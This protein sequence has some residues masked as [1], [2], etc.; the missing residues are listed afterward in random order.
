[1]CIG[2]KLFNCSSRRL[3]RC[4]T[5]LA[6]SAA[7]GWAAA[8]YRVELEAPAP[9][10]KLFSERLDLI[11][12]SERDD[13][14]QQ[15][16]TFMIDAA[17]DEVRKLAS[18]QGYFSPTTTV[19]REPDGKVDTVRLTVHPGPRTHVTSV[20][21]AVRGAAAATSPEQV[22]QLR[23]QWRLAPGAPFTQPAWSDAKQT[24]LRALRERS[25]AVARIVDSQA[26]INADEHQA[27]LHV[28]YDSGPP[29]TFG[30]V[31]VHGAERY[32]EA[33]VMH[34]NPL[35][36]GEPY[37]AAR[38]LEFQRQ[39][40]RLPYYSN[41]IVDME[42]DPAV[43][44]GAPVHVS[45]TEFPLQRFRGG[46]GYTTDTGATVSGRYSHNSFLR[47]ALA[48]D[49]ELIAEQR[50]QLARVAL[51]RPPRPGGFV[52]SARLSTERIRL[53]G[54]EQLSRR[55]GVQRARGADRR[56]T[57]YALT[58]YRDR[59]QRIDGAQVPADIVIEPG[60]HQATVATVEKTW[61]RV[62]D[63]VFPRSGYVLS[64]QAGAALKGLLTDQSFVRG[65]LRGQLYQPARGRDLVLLR[66]ELGLLATKGGSG[67]I[68][69]SLLFRGGGT[70][71][72]RGY[73]F[74]SIGNIRDGTVYPA[75]SLLT[76]SAEY[77]YW[78]RDNWGAALFYDTGMAADRWR[79]RSWFHGA[80][81]GVR[82][83][84][85]VGRVRLDL[86]YGFRDRKL[87]PH[88]ALGVA[89]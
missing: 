16:L 25:Y 42:R 2:T 31:T 73:A 70:D 50:R 58:Y 49:T 39:L 28:T 5:G 64:V 67:A 44:P 89:F 63:L 87:R 47:P 19:L 40:L 71:S 4:C 86:A 83:R 38:V 10:K 36:A 68:P 52:D 84:T 18:T 12:Y 53:E 81:A 14:D 17:P 85:P 26:A 24:A 72:V 79:D 62:D 78:V 74:Q 23:R 15:L 7:S 35:R 46:I 1:M 66:A 80:G 57:T 60:D 59:L 34:A 30:A 9:L 41:V 21:L 6:M 27:R 20:D 88:L 11:R 33:I 61:R 29:F 48:F 13:I 54:V 22:A 75:R 32:P 43:A 55:A 82:W 56:D 69:A 3:V 51:A 45:V 65:Y 8:S 37:S 77:Q 76:A